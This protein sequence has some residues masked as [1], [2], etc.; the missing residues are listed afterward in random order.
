M[1]PVI[2]VKEFIKINEKLVK[3]NKNK[4]STET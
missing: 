1:Y 4:S 2:D 3:F